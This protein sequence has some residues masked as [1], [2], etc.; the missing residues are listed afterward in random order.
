MR[1]PSVGLSA[2]ERRIVE[3]GYLWAEAALRGYRDPPPLVV[4]MMRE[5]LAGC[6]LALRYAYRAVARD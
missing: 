1:V 3:Q 5:W 6:R 4:V 2:D